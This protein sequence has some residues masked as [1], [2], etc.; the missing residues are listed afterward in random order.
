MKLFNGLLC[1]LLSFCVFGFAGSPEGGVELDRLMLVSNSLTLEVRSYPTLESVRED[2]EKFMWLVNRTVTILGEENPEE[3]VFLTSFAEFLSAGSDQ[4]AQTRESVALFLIQ[5][6]KQVFE[7]Q[8]S[9]VP[10]QQQGFNSF[11]ELSKKLIKFIS[12]KTEGEIISFQFQ[13]RSFLDQILNFLKT[14]KP[15][16]DLSKLD[17]AFKAMQ[18]L[19]ESFGYYSCKPLEYGCITNLAKF[20]VG[21]ADLR[22]NVFGWLSNQRALDLYKI[23]FLDLDGRSIIGDLSRSSVRINY[24]KNV[25]KEY[26]TLG[27]VGEYN[28]FTNSLTTGLSGVENDSLMFDGGFKILVKHDEYGRPVSL[29]VPSSVKILKLPEASCYYGYCDAKTIVIYTDRFD[30]IENKFN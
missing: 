27:S 20:V 13:H 26:I 9:F 2:A 4:E 21:I 17:E 12:Q 28:F 6:L 1:F 25:S 22:E 10:V 14:A 18:Q 7:F 19:I 16:Y 30:R 8:E 15:L 11:N 23:N 29:E 3:K 5:N 24:L